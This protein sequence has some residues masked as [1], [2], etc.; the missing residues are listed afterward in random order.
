MKPLY[1]DGPIW[2]YGQF[3][4]K[5]NS[6]LLERIKFFILLSLNQFIRG[7]K[8]PFCFYISSLVRS[9]PYETG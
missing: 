9:V 7:K 5:V 1:F 4:M 2:P 6:E 8:K 3:P